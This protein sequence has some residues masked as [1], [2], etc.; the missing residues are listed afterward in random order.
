MTDGI[1]AWANA[2][3]G[4]GI[5]LALVEGLRALDLWQAPS[6]AIAA[7]FFTASIGRSYG[8]RKLFRRLDE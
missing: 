7:L 6:G 2:I 3:T 4:L 5:S 1:E 8:L